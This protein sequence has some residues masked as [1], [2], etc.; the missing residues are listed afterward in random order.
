VQLPQWDASVASDTQAPL[1]TAS[2]LGQDCPHTPPEHVALPPV[3]AGHAVHDAPHD[4]TAASDT[5][6][7]PQ[8]CVPAAQTHAL[9][10][11]HA[12]PEGDE[13]APE[14][15]GEAEQAALPL[16]HATTPAWAHPPLPLEVHAPPS[17]M[18]LAPHRLVP[19]G[20]TVPHTPDEQLCPA[21]HTRP[22]APQLEPSL[23]SNTHAPAHSVVPLGH[24]APHTPPTHVA[25][26]L[27]GAPH[28]VHDTPHDVTAVSDTQLVPQRCVPAAQTHAP[29]ALHAPP[30]GD[31][32]APEVRGEAGHAGLPELQTSTPVWAHPPLPLEV[33][34]PPNTAQLLPHRLVPAG[35]TVPHTPPEQLCP[36]G[37]ALPHAPQLAP[38]LDSNT[39]A[40]A[41]S[42]VPLGHDA[43]HTPPTHV[44]VPLTGA[45]HAVHDDPHDVTAVSDTQVIPQ[46]CVLG[47]HT[48]GPPASVM[49]V[50][51]GR[52]STATGASTRGASTATGASTRGASTATGASTRGASTATG[53][54]TR[55]APASP[56]SVA[57]SVRFAASSRSGPTTSTTAASAVAPSAGRTGYGRLPAPQPE[58]TPAHKA[59]QPQRVD[60]FI[61]GRLRL[62]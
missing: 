18:Q 6:L 36:A 52:A 42:V 11:L 29:A 43:P 48:G 21:G 57:L 45:P 39:H 61:T 32:H 55:A 22:H 59:A 47:A 12:P 30:K 26:P 15:R 23:D 16:T 56:P 60:D 46:R 24:D 9:A 14:V 8:R 35:Q 20:Q 33:H 2:P 27:T 58:I 53:A 4:V 54:S 49:P 38:L 17:A 1:H 50:S 7:V 40:P 44:A 5:Q 25:V 19:D 3:G 28:A 62:R 41:H 31:E 34:A 51:E 13:H 37:H 10:A